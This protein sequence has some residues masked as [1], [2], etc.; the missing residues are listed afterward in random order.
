M[1]AFSRKEAQPLLFA[2]AQASRNII[3]LD[4]IAVKL[5][6]LFSIFSALAQIF[7]GKYKT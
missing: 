7:H 1:T 2:L 5:L 4:R 3:F 6:D